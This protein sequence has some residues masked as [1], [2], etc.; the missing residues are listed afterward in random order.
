MLTLCILFTLSR[1]NNSEND[2]PNYNPVDVIE[3]E[4]NTRS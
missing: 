2:R 4:H 3:M 1:K